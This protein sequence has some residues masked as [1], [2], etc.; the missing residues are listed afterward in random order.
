MDT[1]K[2]ISGDIEAVFYVEINAKKSL[3]EFCEHEAHT[4]LSPDKLKEAYELI[5]KEAGLTK[6]TAKA[7]EV[8]A[9]EPAEPAK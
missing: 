2:F 6:T 4:G 8:K 5:R 9:E 1:V 3:K 7:A